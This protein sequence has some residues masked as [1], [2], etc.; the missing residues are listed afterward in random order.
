MG[1]NVFVSVANDAV[2]TRMAGDLA[3]AGAAR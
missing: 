3:D 2:K 1:E